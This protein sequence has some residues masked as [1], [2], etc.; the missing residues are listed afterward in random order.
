MK[1]ATIV[2]KR[3]LNEFQCDV[4]VVET[5]KTVRQIPLAPFAGSAR[6]GVEH[7]CSVAD[8][9]PRGLDM[10]IIVEERRVI[11]RRPMMRMEALKL[12]VECAHY[13]GTNLPQIGVSLAPAD[14][15]SEEDIESVY[16]PVV[17]TA[18]R[19]MMA[20]TLPIPLEKPEWLDVES[21]LRE[22]AGT[23]VPMRERMTLCAT[24]ERVEMAERV[25]CQEA[26]AEWPAR[27]K[28]RVFL[29]EDEAWGRAKKKLAGWKKSEGRVIGFTFKKTHTT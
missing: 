9:F 7:K 1:E 15:E 29:V 23:G 2:V 17:R 20:K 6:P 24:A 27:S 12:L 16:N 21:A 3:L 13:L 14:F 11:D 10:R 26:S 8:D 22:M 28:H 18:L 19:L 25:F 5:G 4:T